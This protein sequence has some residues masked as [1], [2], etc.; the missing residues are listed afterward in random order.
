MGVGVVV[1]EYMCVCVQCVCVP[2]GGCG[3][4]RV[5]IS[6]GVGAR[7][8]VSQLERPLLCVC[9]SECVP[10]SGGCVCFHTDTEEYL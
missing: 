9:V 4:A 1:G 2:M 6:V 8:Y 5:C 10:V 3:Y 7:V